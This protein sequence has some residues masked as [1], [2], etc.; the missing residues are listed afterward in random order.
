MLP[1]CG[2]LNKLQKDAARLYEIVHCFG[3]IIKIFSFHEKKEFGN[4]MIARLELRW[5]QWEQPLMLLSIILHPKYRTSKFKP[6]AKKISYS[7]FGQL[8][9]YYYQAWFNE[10]PKKI[11][12]EYLS[13]QQEIF[14]F[15]PETYN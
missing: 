2:A 9:I 5:A 8:I 6:S 10:I 7:H 12:R 14:P 13:Y 11:L 1:L 15:N 3:W 4:H